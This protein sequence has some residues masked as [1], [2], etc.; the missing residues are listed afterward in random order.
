MRRLFD[1]I[2]SFNI[3]FKKL[4]F[5]FFI[6]ILLTFLFYESI[7][8][9]ILG[10]CMFLIISF[11]AGIKG[12]FIS[13][14]FSFISIIYLFIISYV[15]GVFYAEIIH[16]SFAFV[17]VSFLIGNL[18]DHLKSKEDSLIKQI[19]KREYLEN[20]LKSNK[21]YLESIFKA[22]PDIIIHFN[23]KGKIIYTSNTKKEGEFFSKEEILGKNLSFISEELEKN[24]INSMADL[25][26]GNVLSFKFKLNSSKNSNNNSLKK[27]YEARVSNICLN[28]NV[29][30][31]SFE[32][33][34]SIRDITDHVKIKTE[35]ERK[36]VLLDELFSSNPDAIALVS[37]EDDILRINDSF[38]DLFEYKE[39]QII[40]KKINDLIVPKDKIDEANY[41]SEKALNKNKFYVETVRLSK[42][43]KKINVSISSAPITIDG[44]Q[45]GVFAIYRDIT[46]RKKIQNEIEKKS[47]L[48]NALLINFP[49]PVYFKN[50]KREFILAND[51]AAKNLGVDSKNDLIGRTDDDFLPPKDAKISKD[52][53]E[54]IMSELK[55]MNSVKKTGDD[56][57]SLITKAPFIDINGNLKG[58]IGINQDITDRKRAE[59]ELEKERNRIE[60]ISFHD[61]LTGLYNRRFFEE[62]MKRLQNSRLNPI[63]IVV[64]DLDNLKKINDT[65][66]HDKGDE[67]II[68]AANSLKK[69]TRDEDIL[70]RLGGDEFSIILPGVGEKEVES[71]CKRVKNC[72]AEKDVSISLGYAVRKSNQTN[73]EKIFTKADKKMYEEKR[74][75]KGN[76]C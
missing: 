72:C 38:E 25:S 75:K 54:K 35:L 17:F 41:L 43:S 18:F 21:N 1:R 7:N 2:I 66:G 67:Y 11:I 40:G 22:V 59:L 73:L 31:N 13:L 70:A 3:S 71:F 27:T 47:S 39:D 60:Y 36:K 33:I 30:S 24:V 8:I 37:N 14:I 61:K 15:K 76:N 62:E 19:H 45:I 28:N 63:T 55:P 56:S 58:I 44:V 57:W 6:L 69:S 29:N 5:S 34:A 32:F 48:L 20:K 52:E 9:M 4:L 50:K 16:A 23:R 42:N 68:N 10:I 49:E 64:A 74:I 65:Y 46:E 53:E 51:L 12:F 26:C